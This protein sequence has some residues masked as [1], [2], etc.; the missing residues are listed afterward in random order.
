MK[1]TDYV[2]PWT[3]ILRYQLWVKFADLV[4]SDESRRVDL[5]VAPKGRWCCKGQTS[6]SSYAPFSNVL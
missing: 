4:F 3:L 5:K 1:M 2:T 6:L